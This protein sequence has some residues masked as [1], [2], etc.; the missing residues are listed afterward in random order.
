MT[1]LIDQLGQRQVESALGLRARIHRNAEARVAGLRAVDGDD[2]GVTP[3]RLIVGV[4]VAVADED[5]VLH[6]DRRQV[7][8]T[9]PDERVAGDLLLFR[10]EADLPIR[11]L[12][13]PP[14]GE[15]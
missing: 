2:E 8:G 10:F 13:A 5:L 6:P 4:C 9:H 7:A 15:R 3:P 14:D 1:V 11:T 12:P